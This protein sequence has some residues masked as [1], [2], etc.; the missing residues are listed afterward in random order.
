MFK[1]TF[2]KNYVG[3]FRQ[4]LIIKKQAQRNETVNNISLHNLS[5]DL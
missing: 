3:Y 2:E 5:D 1:F 4:N